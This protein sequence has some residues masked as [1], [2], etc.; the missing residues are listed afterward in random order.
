M[1]EEFGEAFWEER[2]RGHTA[3]S[4]TRPNPQLVAEAG[5]LA[6]G[7]AL[8]A[9]CGRGGDAVWLASRG[10]RV[11]AV[12]ISATALGR[13]REHAESLGADIAGRVDWVR[14]DLTEWTPAEEHFDLVSTHY[15]HTAGSR[16][17][18]FGRLAAA[19]APGGTLLVVGHQPSDHGPGTSH[20]PP[21]EV[22]FTAREV[23]AGLDPHLWDVVVAEARSRST[24]D[25][26]GHE[27]TLH[28]AVLRARRRR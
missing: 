24:T 18:L 22:H 28:D 26:D 16:E 20:A 25:H 27:I 14:A 13:A 7:R 3:T 12:D 5:D 21:P 17:A 8:D 9:G 4:G 10:W 1:S 19:V 15:V 23:A 11:M 6:P 2:Y